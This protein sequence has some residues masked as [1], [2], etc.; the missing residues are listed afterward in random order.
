M[1]SLRSIWRV[2][3]VAIPI[4]VLVLT[5]GAA[6]AGQT[7]SLDELIGRLRQGGYACPR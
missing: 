5:A 7:P 2:G 1:T 4:C 6:V 3:R